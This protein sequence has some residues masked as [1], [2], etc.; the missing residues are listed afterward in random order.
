MTANPPVPPVLL[1]TLAGPSQRPTQ[2]WPTPSC[3][4]QPDGSEP[5]SKPSIRPPVWYW[6]PG[7]RHATVSTLSAT[8][9]GPATDF[10]TPSYPGE[11][12]LR[13]YESSKGTTSE[14]FP[15][16]GEVSA[17]APATETVAPLGQ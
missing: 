10:V 5:E 8:S 4:V 6:Y 9:A 14:Y 17:L 3:T 1:P 7:A 12:T 13:S 16:T 2:P 11:L 15:V